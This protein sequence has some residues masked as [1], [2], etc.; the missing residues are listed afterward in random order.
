MDKKFDRLKRQQQRLWRKAAVSIL[1]LHHNLAILMAFL[2]IIV[3]GIFWVLVDQKL[4]DQL[5]SNARDYGY[6]I[7]RY[8]SD[9]LKQLIVAKD[10]DSQQKYL[11]R[12]TNDPV[13]IEAR[14]FDHLGTLLAQ[15]SVIDSK[16]NTQ[17]SHN[18]QNTLSLLEDI[19]QDQTRLGIIQLK[20]DRYLQEEPLQKMLNTLAIFTVVLMIIAAFIAWLVTKRLTR[21]LRKLLKF[22]L[23]TP[24]D[25]L[26]AN[27]DVA[28][29]LKLM[30]ESS[31]D[32]ADSPAPVSKAEES[33][34]HQLLAADS[35]AE[36]GEVVILK[37]YFPDLADW[38]KPDSG[39]PNVHLLR[40]LDRLL[41]MTIHSQQGHLLSFDGITAQACFGL[42][43]KQESAVYRAV[44]CSLLLK[45]LLEELSLKP[46]ICLQ[47]ERRL[48]IRHM[49][50]TPVAIPIHASEDDTELLFS[51]DNLWLLLHKNISNDQRLLEQMQL[52]KIAENWL[53][54]DETCQTALSMIDRQLTWIRYL[55]AGSNND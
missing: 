43:G 4:E 33:G 18:Q 5:L 39:T 34:I 30:L 1:S 46:K 26:I 11:Q 9:D 25:N 41:I 21:S 2:T 38:L 51:T 19:Y 52:T 35:V 31:T 15:S 23:N 12:L 32:T 48:L 22:P 44:S 47:K 54:I 49:K 50:R 7:T 28:S 14:L 13:I 16:T 20:I 3:L 40:Q 37:L 10:Q 6:G 36:S 42:D 53:S 24:E 8:A 55:L 29:E 27:L 17:H 45:I